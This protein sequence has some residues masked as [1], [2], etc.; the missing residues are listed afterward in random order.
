MRQWTIDPKELT[1]RQ[2]DILLNLATGKPQ[3]TNR[4]TRRALEVLGLI[5]IADRKSWLIENLTPLG[6]LVAMAIA[7]DG[8]VHDLNKIPG[9]KASIGRI[10]FEVEK[11]DEPDD[12]GI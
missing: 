10:V 1:D 6:R 11:D 3:M 7:F 4:N 8:Y 5:R 2:R 9:V 12:D